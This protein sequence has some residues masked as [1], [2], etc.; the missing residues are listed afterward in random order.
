MGQNGG[1]V[2]GGHRAGQGV[3]RWE[4]GQSPV[5]CGLCAHPSGDEETQP[6]E[7]TSP[8]LAARLSYKIQIRT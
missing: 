2:P 7:T 3:P 6:E 8:P 4:L 1:L 5:G